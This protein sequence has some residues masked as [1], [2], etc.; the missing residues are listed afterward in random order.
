MYTQ[1]HIFL[2]YSSL[3][4]HIFLQSREICRI[5]LSTNKD[6]RPA[7]YLEKCNIIRTYFYLCQFHTKPPGTRLSRS[8]RRK[9]IC[10][11][12]CIFLF[13]L[14]DFWTRHDIRDFNIVYPKKQFNLSSATKSKKS[15][16]F[17]TNST[18]S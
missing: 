2:L 18:G 8:G 16:I 3:K 11:R 14:P 12:C 4:L 9:A 6:G 13:I 15:V 10:L 5:K 1:L 17:F 7:E